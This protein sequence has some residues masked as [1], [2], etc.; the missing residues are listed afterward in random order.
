ML[1]VD[2]LS[3]N[4]FDKHHKLGGLSTAGY[5]FGSWNRAVK[6]AGLQPYETGGNKVGPKISDQELLEEIIRLHHELSK[7]PSEKEMARFGKYSPKPYR[8]R[9]GSWSAA[10]TAAYERFGIPDDNSQS[11]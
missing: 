1:G 5:Q 9:W 8:D 11:G 7:R 4:E 2:R 6:A 10:Q 3:S